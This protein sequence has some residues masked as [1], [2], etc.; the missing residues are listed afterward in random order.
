MAA[1]V[2]VFCIF[3]YSPF[4]IRHLQMALC[5]ALY[6]LRYCLSYTQKSQITTH[7]SQIELKHLKRWNFETLEHWNFRNRS[8]IP[9]GE[10]LGFDRQIYCPSSPTGKERKAQSVKRK[11]MAFIRLFST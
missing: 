3:F 5:Y 6:A 4:V 7:K 10:K 8:L 2:Q 9:Y 11:E 1:D